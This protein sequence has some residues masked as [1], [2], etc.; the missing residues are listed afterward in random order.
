MEIKASAV[1]GKDAIVKFSKSQIKDN[2]IIFIITIVLSMF[3]ALV[4]IISLTGRLYIEGIGLLLLMAFFLL[5][6]FYLMPIINYKQNMRKFGDIKQDY[7]FADKKLTA[8]TDSCGVKGS[9]E[10]E[11]ASLIKITET[12]E[13]WFIYITKVQ[14]MI[15]DKSTVTDGSIEDL[16]AL[17]IKNIDNGKYKMK[18]K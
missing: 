16:R 13:Y 15:V 3:C 8:T 18:C 9:S 7:V 14:A 10:I 5:Y 12:K 1:Y 4:S 11:Y 6:T 2:K 17:L